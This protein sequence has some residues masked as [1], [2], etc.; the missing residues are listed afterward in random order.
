M[1]R[2]I[3]NFQLSFFK[4]VFVRCFVSI[5]DSDTL[6][7]VS[8]TQVSKVLPMLERGIGIHH[9]G[10]L[11]ILKEVI[12]ILFQEGLIKA[13]FAT[14]TFAMGLNMP[15][16]TVVFSSAKKFDGKD[17]RYISSG[18]YI[19]MSGRAGRRGEISSKYIFLMYYF[20]SRHP[21]SFYSEDRH[22]A[23]LF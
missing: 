20:V 16:R 13:L 3:L 15:A 1:S 5:T 11:P 10:L 8:F 22:Q 4:S 2:S 9:G 12:E 23:T 19:Q 17:T 7:E 14:E 6:L 18:E 21:F